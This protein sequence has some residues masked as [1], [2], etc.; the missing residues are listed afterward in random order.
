[1]YTT[2]REETVA[3]LAEMISRQPQLAPILGPMWARLKDM[4]QADKISKLLLAVAPPQVQQ[5]EGDD[6]DIPPHVA[7]QM[8]QMQQQM[9]QMNDL[10]GKAADEIQKLQS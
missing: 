6:T 8:Q 1:S 3:Q 7:A 9:Q 4:P 10:L 2:A 5:I